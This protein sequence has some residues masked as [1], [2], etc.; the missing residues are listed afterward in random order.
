MW[1]A[2][3]N[4]RN[5]GCKWVVVGGSFVTNKP[6][7]HDVDVVWSYNRVDLSR[8]DPILLSRD[9]T[10]RAMEEKYGGQYF[11]Q[12][13]LAPPNGS[14]MLNFFRYGRNGMGKGVVL[15]D[16]AMLP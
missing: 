16:L 12:D 4:L 9:P 5:A 1:S 10:M 11:A 14:G 15:V 13:L 2:F 7:P 6:V 3:E 8:L